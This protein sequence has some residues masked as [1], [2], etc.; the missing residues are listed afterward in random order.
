MAANLCGN[1]H[2]VSMTKSS[3]W[4]VIHIQNMPTISVRRQWAYDK[5]WRAEETEKAMVISKWS[6]SIWSTPHKWAATIHTRASYSLRQQNSLKNLSRL[7]FNNPICHRKN[8]HS[9]ILSITIKC[10]P[11]SS[12]SKHINIYESKGKVGVQLHNFT[13]SLYNRNNQKRKLITN[14]VSQLPKM[15]F[16]Y[17]IRTVWSEN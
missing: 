2:I 6:G 12:I 5:M 17:K 16:L 8:F 4:D 7:M 10:R 9:G 11:G 15:S 13:T 14:W 3:E 1:D